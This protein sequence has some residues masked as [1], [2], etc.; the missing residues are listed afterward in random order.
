L[1]PDATSFR[2]PPQRL[3]QQGFFTASKSAKVGQPP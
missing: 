3:Q 2:N 1:I